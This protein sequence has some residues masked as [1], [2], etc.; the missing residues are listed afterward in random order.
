MK[1]KLQNI[2]Q[3]ENGFSWYSFCFMNLH[4]AFLETQLSNNNIT[5]Y[6]LERASLFSKSLPSF[7]QLS[8]LS[9]ES[10]KNEEILKIMASTFLLNVFFKDEF[11]F[12]SNSISLERKID[13]IQFKYS[14]IGNSLQLFLYIQFFILRVYNFLFEQY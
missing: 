2:I 1:I 7:I 3:N 11:Q 8:H 5:A 13:S 12:L 4:F 6:D 14:N 10:H 9:F